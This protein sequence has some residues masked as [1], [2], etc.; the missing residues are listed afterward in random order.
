MLEI[1]KY[2]EDIRLL[3]ERFNNDFKYIKYIYIDLGKRFS[4]DPDYALGN[5]KMRN[6]I[7]RNIYKDKNKINEHFVSGIIICKSLCYICEYIFNNLG[8]NTSSILDI[9]DGKHTYNSIV[10]YDRVYFFDLQLDLKYIN[11]NFRTRYFLYTLAEDYT[12][13]DDITIDYSIGYLNKG[14]SHEAIIDSILTK[15]SYNSSL[16]YILETLFNNILIHFNI[17]GYIERNK[18]T[19]EFV[20]KC[21]N[22]TIYKNKFAFC[23]CYNTLKNEYV[24]II[25]IKSS[26]TKV[27]IFIFDNKEKEYVNITED[28]LIFL[29]K[30][31]LKIR[32]GGIFTSKMIVTTK[33]ITKYILRNSAKKLLQ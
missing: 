15:V 21:L 29:L 31:V 25:S 2:I 5:S 7:Y 26:N 6:K 20:S 32:L 33:N 16:E 24:N 8:F 12:I 22:N 18:L 4:F 23:H 11:A 3:R 28:E 9:G 13:N 27:F 1:D 10:V 17:N 30:S 19:I 14:Q